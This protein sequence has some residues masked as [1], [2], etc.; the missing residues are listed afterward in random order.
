[1]R[2]L[3]AIVIVLI[4][5]TSFACCACPDLTNAMASKHSLPAG[6]IIQDDDVML[7]HMSSTLRTP[8]IPGWR[9]D[10]IGH[11]TLRPIPE[12]H[13]ILLSEVSP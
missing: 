8:D 6:A 11:K 12:K 1:M 3:G 10:V 7:V 4:T 9:S 2:I 13:L 5:M